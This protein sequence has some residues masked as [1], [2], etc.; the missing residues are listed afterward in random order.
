MIQIK[1]KKP[2]ITN[3]KI[4]YKLINQSI[5]LILINSTNLRNF[6]CVLP[7]EATLSLNEK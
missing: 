5:I 6:L 7:G 2:I 4:W 3:H 1:K